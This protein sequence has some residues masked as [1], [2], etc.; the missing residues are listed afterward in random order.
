[1]SFAPKRQAR[2]SE[3]QFALQRGVPAMIG[4]MGEAPLALLYW[5]VVYGSSLQYKGPHDVFFIC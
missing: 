4:V 2:G 5:E 1:M 3:V